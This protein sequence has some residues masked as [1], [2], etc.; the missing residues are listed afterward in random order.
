VHAVDHAP[1]APGLFGN[2]LQGHVNVLHGAADRFGRVQQVERAVGVAGNGGQGLVEFVAEQRSH[3]AH[4]GQA[5]R[6][7][8]SL[9][10]GAREFFHPPLLADVQD[11]AHPAG[12]FALGADQRGFDHEHRKACAVLA[13]EDRFVALARRGIARQSHGLALLVFAHHFGW[14]VRHGGAL[15]HQF[16]GAEAHHFTEG[17]VDVGDSPFAVTG[18]QSG[19]QRVFHGLAKGQGVGQFALGLQAPA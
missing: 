9:L 2:A 10:A 18:A 1:G 17:G 7:L 13:H 14:P 3:L 4:G 11:R 16:F 15:P 12:L 8:Q 5:C 19:D 6:G